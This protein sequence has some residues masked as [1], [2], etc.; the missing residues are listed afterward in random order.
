MLG[1][2]AKTFFADSPVLAYPIFALL[3]FLAAFAILSVRAWRRNPTELERLARMPLDDHPNG[4]EDS[5]RSEQ[6]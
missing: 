5:N 4:V 2:L 3:L 6:P 1:H